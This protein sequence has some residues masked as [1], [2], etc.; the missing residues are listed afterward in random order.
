MDEKDIVVDESMTGGEDQ[1]LEISSDLIR[2]HINTIILRCLYDGDK[3]GYEI[4]NEI[5][6]I[7]LFYVVGDVRYRGYEEYI[8]VSENDNLWDLVKKHQEGIIIAIIEGMDGMI[9]ET[10]NSDEFIG[11][12]DTNMILDLYIQNELPEYVKEE[13][14][15]LENIDKYIEYYEKEQ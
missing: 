2:G 6:T 10:I 15:K 12:N 5:E 14:E 11:L 13:L 3:Y 7:E 4:I 9:E 8:Q 1:S